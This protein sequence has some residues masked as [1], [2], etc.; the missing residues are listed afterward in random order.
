MRGRAPGPA[1]LPSSAEAKSRTG[2]DAHAPATDQ[3]GVARPGLE[4]SDIG[5]YEV[6]APPEHSS[7]LQYFPVNPCPGYNLYSTLV[8]TN[9]SEFRTLR[10]I[11][12]TVTLPAGTWFFP[13]QASGMDYTYDGNTIVFTADTL[14]PEEI[15]LA[16]LTIHTSSALMHGVIL[17]TTWEVAAEALTPVTYE[18]VSV[19]DTT[20]CG[21]LPEPTPTYEPTATPTPEVTVT[22]TATVVA[23]PTNTPE[24]QPTIPSIGFLP[25]VFK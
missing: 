15:A 6:Q 24:P 17:T 9:T 3:R 16:E 21:S 4:T 19:V 25:L 1:A 14:G 13:G 7:R 18:A 2:A 23:T 10:G 5:A 8:I 22:L 12:A 11:T 20:A